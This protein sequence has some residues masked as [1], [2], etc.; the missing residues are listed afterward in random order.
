MTDFWVVYVV[1]IA[2]ASVWKITCRHQQ[3]SKDA[4]FRRTNPEIWLRKQELEEA[5][6]QRQHERKQAGMKAGGNIGMILLK[7]FLGK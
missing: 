4:E 5:E 3:E 2:I 1:F 7:I 6:K